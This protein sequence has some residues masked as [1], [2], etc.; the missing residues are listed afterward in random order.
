MYKQRLSVEYVH[1]SSPNEKMLVISFYILV[2]TV[3]SNSY[4]K[5]KLSSREYIAFSP[6]SMGL[7]FFESKG[8][9]T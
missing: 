3:S 1:F 7:G 8:V 9:D 4:S 5:S 2:L 6:I